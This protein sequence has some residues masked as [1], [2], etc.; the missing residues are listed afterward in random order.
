MVI[1]HKYELRCRATW[2]HVPQG[3]ILYLY[4]FRK[5]G[6]LLFCES[7]LLLLGDAINNYTS[8]GVFINSI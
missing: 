4:I 6:R 8:G 7:R 1:E 2:Y 5:R 3:Y